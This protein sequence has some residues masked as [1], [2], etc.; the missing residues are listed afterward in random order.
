MIGIWILVAFYAINV[1]LRIY[2]IVKCER[3]GDKNVQMVKK[4][5]RPADRRE[6]DR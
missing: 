3:K 2:L 4:K 1:A 6:K 5:R